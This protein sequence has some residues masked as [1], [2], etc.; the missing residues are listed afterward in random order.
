MP[1]SIPCPICGHSCPPEARV[2]PVCGVTMPENPPT[3]Q[4]IAS[5]AKPISPAP[6]QAVSKDDTPPPAPAQNA[7]NTRA[8]EATLHTKPA[9]P[10]RPGHTGPFRIRRPEPDAP[11]APKGQEPLSQP[12]Q[13][14]AGPP[15][16]AGQGTCSGCGAP[17]DPAARFCPQCGMATAAAPR[18]IDT[19][20]ATCPACGATVKPTA[21][22][23]PQCGALRQAVDVHINQM[24]QP[25]APM[26]RDVPPPPP[27]PYA[28]TTPAPD[29][30]AS[31]APPQ[32]P[33]KPSRPLSHG[34]TQ[35]PAPPKQQTVP[36]PGLS[37]YA[38]A[39]PNGP[40]LK[41]ASIGRR[42]LALLLD[43]IFLNLLLAFPNAAMMQSLGLAPQEGAVAA[44]AA[45]LFWC[46]LYFA[47]F[48]SS[49][50]QATPGKRAMGIVVTDVAG[51]RI[52]LGRASLRYV[53]KFLSGF[54][55]MIGFVMAFF[56]SQKQALHDR[57]AGTLVLRRQPEATRQISG[58][59]KKTI[60][61]RPV[62]SPARAC[63]HCGAALSKR[64]AKFCGVC[65]GRIAA[66][67]GQA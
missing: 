30:A 46:W 11:A 26:T 27:P 41:Y 38:D 5:S 20:S 25:A 39:P 42:F 49:R 16:D 28:D 34:A 19:S 67:D 13:P 53:G 50:F 55:L 44:T 31:P 15:L 56:S 54:I 10:D 58:T 52:S 7:D 3:P 14:A 6:P 8:T 32:P 35:I 64:T 40:P 17:L 43:G 66:S 9:P 22:F 29:T 57:L 62:A 61:P 23:C 12:S 4:K 47:L 51:R 36:P 48:E 33:K 21:K 24:A 37:G 65:G 63:P 2:C 18:P 60:T 59:S 45:M 1:A